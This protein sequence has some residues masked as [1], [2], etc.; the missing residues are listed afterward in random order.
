MAGLRARSGFIA[1]PP[2]P[3]P[4][5]KGAIVCQPQNRLLEISRELDTGSPALDE[6]TDGWQEGGSKGRKEGGEERARLN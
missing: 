3:N 2:P 4:E 6:L 1:P 5:F